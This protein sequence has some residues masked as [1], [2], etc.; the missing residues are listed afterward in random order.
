ME[1]FEGHAR[2]IEFEDMRV[3]AAESN[4]K[5]EAIKAKDAQSAAK[6]RRNEESKRKRAA[7]STA[8]EQGVRACASRN[9]KA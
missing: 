5:Q 7:V 9:G 3:G 4:G 8:D 6:S 2:A 1:G